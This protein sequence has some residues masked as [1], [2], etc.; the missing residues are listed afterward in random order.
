MGWEPEFSFLFRASFVPLDSIDT[1][2]N[3]GCWDLNKRSTAHEE[4]LH[5]CERRPVA[6]AV[7]PSMSLPFPMFVLIVLL[8]EL[9]TGFIHKKNKVQSEVSGFG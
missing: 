6:L 1:A 9:R 7:V 4:A 5:D 2:L 3:G 8:A